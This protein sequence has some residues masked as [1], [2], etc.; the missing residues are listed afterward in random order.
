M[1]RVHIL[2][3]TITQQNMS[4]N[5]P[6][7][8]EG[9][10]IATPFEALARFAFALRS[11][12]ILVLAT[13]EPHCRLGFAAL[14]TCPDPLA[15][16]ASPWGCKHAH[17]KKHTV[18]ITLHERVDPKTNTTNTIKLMLLTSMARV[19][20]ACFGMCPDL[21]TIFCDPCLAR[22][23]LVAIVVGN[24]ALVCSPRCWLAAYPI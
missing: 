4:P 7:Y 3:Q 19:G 10:V 6:S 20:H 2:A 9:T 1:G 12:A 22:Y 5:N 11:M 18:F 24:M 8:S 13:E 15:S 14:A 23:T 16:T 21:L 17:A